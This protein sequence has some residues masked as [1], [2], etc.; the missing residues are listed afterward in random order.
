MDSHRDL[1][2]G[3]TM[4][5]YKGFPTEIDRQVVGAVDIHEGFPDISRYGYL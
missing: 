5:I 4:D 3:G 2:V 1:Q